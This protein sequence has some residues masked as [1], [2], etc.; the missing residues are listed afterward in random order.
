MTDKFEFIEAEENAITAEAI[1]LPTVARM[2]ALMGV[3]KSGYYEWRSRPVSATQQRREL[4]AEKIRA[5]FAAFN[6][7]YGYRR[8]HAELLRGASGSG[9]SWSPRSRV[10]WV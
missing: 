6:A 9:R 2:C 10:R 3:S 5:L 7:T 4:L 1:E 8:I